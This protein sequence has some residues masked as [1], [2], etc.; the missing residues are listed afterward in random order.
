MIKTEQ[1]ADRH[2]GVNKEDTEVMLKKIGV[3]DLEQ[4]IDQTVPQAIRLNH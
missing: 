2:I 4:L 3:T 1:F